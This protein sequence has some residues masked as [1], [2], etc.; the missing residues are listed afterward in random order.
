MSSN[1]LCLFR[2]VIFTWSEKGFLLPLFI[3]NTH[4]T[5]DKWVERGIKIPSFNAY[6]CI[7]KLLQKHKLDKISTKFAANF[8]FSAHFTF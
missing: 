7:I 2:I 6:Y 5:L 1:I 3:N 4:F 8:L